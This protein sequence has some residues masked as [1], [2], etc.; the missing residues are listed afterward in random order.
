MRYSLIHG[1]S[2]EHKSSKYEQDSLSYAAWIIA[3]ISFKRPL[4]SVWLLS[5][6]HERLGSASLL[7]YTR[8]T[9]NVVGGRGRNEDE[10]CRIEFT[11][12][13]KHTRNKRK[14]IITIKEVI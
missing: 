1:P 13:H 8:M 9:L 14:Q 11:P 3:L 10:E 12:V 2:H 6:E 7:I 4:A 5:W